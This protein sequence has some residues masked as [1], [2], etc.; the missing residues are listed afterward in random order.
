MNF[1]DVAEPNISESESPFDSGVAIYFSCVKF[2]RYV[3]QSDKIQ[4]HNSQ[5]LSWDS[6]FTQ[7]F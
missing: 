6:S 3:F 1:K 4:S 2:F 7:L 5:T